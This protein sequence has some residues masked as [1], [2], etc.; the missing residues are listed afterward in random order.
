MIVNQTKD[1]WEVIYH[2]AHALL[3]AQ[4]A[5]QWDRKL[6]PARFFETIAAISHH[7]DLEKEWEDAQVTEVGAPLDFT[8]D[9]KSSI[10]QLEKLVESAQHRG[11]WVAMLVSTHICFLNQNRRG[12]AKEWDSFLDEQLKKQEQW[13]KALKINKDEAARAYDFMEWCDRLSLIL[14]QQQLPED[15]RA[16]EISSRLDNQR[17]DVRQLSDD[18]VTV[19]PWC[20]EKDEF[21]VNIEAIHLNQL[22]F[23]DNAALQ[24][25]FREAPIEVVQ[26]HFA[27]SA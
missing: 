14:C 15:Q 27:K 4:L 16:L 24:A 20:F 9:A 6:I 2:R 23:K 12:T 11:R 7:D 8:L 26:W 10:E 21:T 13:R 18:K 3:A 5:G 17:Y 22:K 1:G 25:A 19:E